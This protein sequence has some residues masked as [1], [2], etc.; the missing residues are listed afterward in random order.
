MLITFAGIVV[1]FDPCL[2]AEITLGVLQ[3]NV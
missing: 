2:V 3:R 1:I